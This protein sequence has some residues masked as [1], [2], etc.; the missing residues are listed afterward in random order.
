MREAIS[1]VLQVSKGSTFFSDATFRSATFDG[2]ANFLF[3]NFH[4]DVS[5][6]S[7][8]FEK[9]VAFRN[10]TFTGT[11]GFVTV[12]FEGN[13]SYTECSFHTRGTATMAGIRF[14]DAIFSKS[15]S[16]RECHFVHSYP[17]FTNTDLY[18]V[19]DFSAD[20]KFWPEGI[21]TP[22][23]EARDS[24]GIIRN[25]LAKKGLTEDQ[26]FFFRR[27]MLFTS[28]HEEPLRRFPYQV[29]RY[30]S[31][32]GHSIARPLI[33]LAFIWTFGFVCFWGYFSGCCVPAPSTVID[34]PIGSAIGLSFSNLFPLFGFNRLYFG[35]EFM[36][37]L[38]ASLKALSSVQTV[39]SLPFLF[40]LGLGLRQRFRLR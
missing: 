35:A 26:H 3:A 11:V 21:S 17:E 38:P 20:E 15:T 30:L 6:A 37:F 4:K 14:T 1:P 32:Y 5:F 12:Q 25:L 33:G 31:D 29:Y 19:T 16:F 7:S 39:V 10:T 18:P 13:T 23:K 28:H 8:T 9:E 24:C 40:F 34:R 22:E 36:K 2:F 27:E